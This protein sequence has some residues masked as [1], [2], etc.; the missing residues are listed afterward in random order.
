MFTLILPNMLKKLD[1]DLKNGNFLV[2]NELCWADFL[3]GGFYT[4][5]C[6]NP[7]V[8]APERRAQLL[9]DFPNFKAYGERF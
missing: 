1:L 7:M 6:I 8:Y 3:I 5:F 9:K 2:G 4:N